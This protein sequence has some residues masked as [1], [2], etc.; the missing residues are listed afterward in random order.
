MAMTGRYLLASIA[1]LSLVCSCKAQKP[2]ERKRQGPVAVVKQK[3]AV[4]SPAQRAE[5]RFPPD[6]IAKLELAAGTEAE[7][8]FVTVVMHSENLKGEQAFESRKLAGFSVRTKNGDEL[9]D[10]YRAGLRVQ[11]Y[12]IFKSHKG[13]GSLADIVTVIKGNNSY[14]ILKV[15]GTEAQS[16]QLDTNAIIAWLKARQKEGTFVITGAGTDWLEARFIKP[17]LDMEPFAEKISAFA[18][19]V[20][21]HGPRTSEKQ[22]ERMRISNGFFLV[23]D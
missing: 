23:W 19:D 18:P 22:A 13:Y 14:D 21:E 16:Y 5:L 9:I 4:L 2:V 20:L 3:H 1:L 7:P 15:Q 10:S 8:F 6:L 12:L 17:P 11:G